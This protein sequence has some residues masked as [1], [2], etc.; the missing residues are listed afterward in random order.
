MWIS[1]EEHSGRGKSIQAEGTAHAAAHRL[2]SWRKGWEGLA[3]AEGGRSINEV[4][5]AV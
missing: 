3:G 4:R 2:A 5:E 1:R